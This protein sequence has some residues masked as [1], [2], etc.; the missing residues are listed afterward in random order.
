M[1]Q[2]TPHA[3]SCTVGIGPPWDIAGGGPVAANRAVWL[4]PPSEGEKWS[5]G[6]WV[7]GCVPPPV[8]E[9]VTVPGMGAGIGWHNQGHERR[10]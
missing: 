1:P 3:A 10:L 4:E 8:W 7:G 9:G 6:Q 2:Q 5:R